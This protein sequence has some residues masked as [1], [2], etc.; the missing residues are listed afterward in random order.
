[1]VGAVPIYDEDVKARESQNLPTDQHD[2]GQATPR[3]KLPA[4]N[5][6]PPSAAPQLGLL[7]SIPMRNFQIVLGN[8]TWEEDAS[9]EQ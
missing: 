1:M 2:S 7:F 3:F 9:V 6:T 4:P 5:P 8:P